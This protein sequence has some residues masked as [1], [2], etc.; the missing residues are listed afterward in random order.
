MD[1]VLE[2]SRVSG[3]LLRL[4][5]GVAGDVRARIPGLLAARTCCVFKG[6]RYCRSIQISSITASIPRNCT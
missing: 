2:A 6:A 4:L 5:S 3:V 1:R